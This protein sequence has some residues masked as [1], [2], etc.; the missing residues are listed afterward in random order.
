MLLCLMLLLGACQRADRQLL[1]GNWQA[2]GF[3]EAGQTVNT[4]LDSVKMT[5]NTDGSYT[6]RSIG[7]YQE[8][9]RFDVSGAYLMLTDTSHGGSKKRRVKVVFQDEKNLKLAMENAGKS[10][11]LFLEK[12]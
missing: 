6:F 5:F 11:Q 7:F 4:P 2:T 12:R 8:K 3:Y 1:T 9:G 10:Q